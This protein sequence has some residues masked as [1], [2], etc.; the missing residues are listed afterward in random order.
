MLSAKYQTNSNCKK[1]GPHI[2]LYDQ[3]KKA[4][5]LVESATRTPGRFQSHF[6]VMF[7]A[8]KSTHLE[9]IIPVYFPVWISYNISIALFIELYRIAL[10]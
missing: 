6:I 10:Q 5:H 4:V 3:K 9:R 2:D 7:P 1:F 8:S